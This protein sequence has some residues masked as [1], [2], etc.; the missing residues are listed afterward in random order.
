MANARWPGPNV[1]VI[2][3]VAGA[4]LPHVIAFSPQLFDIAERYRILCASTYPER[5]AADGP[6]AVAP[7]YRPRRV[8]S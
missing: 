8:S 5:N 7:P 1:T 3:L 4:K 6:K 2:A